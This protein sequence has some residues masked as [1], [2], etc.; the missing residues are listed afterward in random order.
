MRCTETDPCP[1]CAGQE[2]GDCYDYD[3]SIR[4]ITV[5]GKI[6]HGE[7][8]AARERAAGR[9]PVE[10]IAW[11]LDRVGEH[12]GIH[13]GSVASAC[14]AAL[15]FLEP[16]ATEGQVACRACLWTEGGEL[17]LADSYVGP[18]VYGD[19][20]A[21]RGFCREC[22]TELTPETVINVKDGSY[23]LTL[24]LGRDDEDGD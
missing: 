3:F 13:Y 7:A 12:M 24:G 4:W 10:S 22:N 19:E 5:R 16:P 14:A 8:E 11:L 2:A 20:G 1:V 6:G 18:R 23:G 15:R 9:E 17:Y 21:P